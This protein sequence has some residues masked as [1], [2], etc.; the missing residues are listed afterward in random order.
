MQSDRTPQQTRETSGNA[1]RRRLSLLLRGSIARGD[2][3]NGRLP[4]ESEIM[5]DYG[6]SRGVVRDVLQQLNDTGVVT[7]TQG[8][9]TRALLASP[10]RR[11]PLHGGGIVAPHRVQ[12][13]IVDTPRTVEKRMNRCGPRVLRLEHLV[14]VDGR[15]CAVSTSYVALPA[16]AHLEDAEFGA[17]VH[18]LLRNGGLMV[19][20][21]EHVIGAMLA[22][23]ATAHRLGV[24]TSSPLLSLEQTM[25]DLTGE[26]LCFS[27]TAI[28]P[29]QMSLFVETTDVT[30]G[31]GAEPVTVSSVG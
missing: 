1:A 7:R 2:F 8:V 10:A 9:G 18:D 28:R 30:P 21:T 14:I 24:P 26:A 11:H 27:T 16:A 22:D 15:V 25:Y 12:R 3:P 23:T 29:D 17:G 4:R 6:A 31:I 5:R 20:S 19:S 13:R